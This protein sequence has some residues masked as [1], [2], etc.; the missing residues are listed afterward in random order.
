MLYSAKAAVRRRL[1]SLRSHVVRSLDSTVSKKGP[2]LLLVDPGLKDFYG[3]HFEFTNL[4]RSELQDDFSVKVY[5]HHDVTMPVFARLMTRPIFDDG[6]H[7]GYAAG[8]FGE[9]YRAMTSSIALGLSRVPERDLNTNTVVAMHTV[10]GFQLGGLARWYTNLHRENR[11]KLFLQF[12]FPFEHG[13][14]EADWPEALTH[15]R[16]ASATL[17][18][19]GRVIFSCNSRPLAARIREQISQ[20]CALMPLPTAWPPHIS[21]PDPGVVFG[22][23]GGFRSEKGADLMAEAI[24]EFARKHPDASFIVHV[25][26][27][28]SKRLAERA[29]RDADAPRVEIIDK[30]FSN[31]EEYFANFC[32]ARCILLPYDPEQYAIRTSGIFMEALGL[33]RMILTTRATWMAGELEGYRGSGIV[34]PEFTTTALL[35][36]LEAA[37]EKL[38]TMGEQLSPN[39]DVMR[40]HSAASFCSRM[41][42]VVEEEN[43]PRHLS[44]SVLNLQI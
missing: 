25:P 11:P 29:L 24:P 31:K 23:F 21:E 17:A 36:G 13:I 15:A 43:E 12:Q 3:H 39:K 37:R 14:R 1:Y 5:S 27:L 41:L 32:R 28:D 9:A 34:I 26:Y 42:R 19:S 7:R 33:G 20:P 6:P 38:L 18:G 40:E 16:E 8:E 2:K 44:N 22:F 35:E 4:I 10:T 30:N